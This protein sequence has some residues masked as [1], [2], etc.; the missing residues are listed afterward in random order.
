MVVDPFTPE[1]SLSNRLMRRYMP[2]LDQRVVVV[3]DRGK[4]NEEKRVPN[5]TLPRY[6]SYANS[7]NTSISCS[8]HWDPRKFSAARCWPTQMAISPREA[9][10]WSLQTRVR[11]GNGKNGQLSK[12]SRL[13]LSCKLWFWG[14]SPMSFEAAF[15]RKGNLYWILGIRL[16]SWFRLGI[17]AGIFWD[18]LGMNTGIFRWFGIVEWV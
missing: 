11:S 16:E 5:L 14:V 8:R 17:F 13:S 6:L 3:L 1:E 2:L 15:W 7:R 12:S 9:S 4:A 18:E 10:H